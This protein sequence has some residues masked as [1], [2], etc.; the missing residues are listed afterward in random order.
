MNNLNYNAETGWNALGTGL[1]RGGGAFDDSM[2]PKYRR[3]FE[4][5]EGEPLRQRQS[6][7]DQDVLAEALADYRNTRSAFGAPNESNL[8]QQTLD[9]SLSSLASSFGNYSGTALENALAGKYLG[10]F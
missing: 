1:F 10:I 7:F 6:G 9:S 2:Q 8:V 4:S 3:V 5:I